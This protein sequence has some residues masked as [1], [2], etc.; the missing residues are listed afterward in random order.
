MKFW[1]KIVDIIM[2]SL[3][4]LTLALW[5]LALVKP[6]L[7]KDFIAWIEKIVY[8]LWN[9]NYLIVF[10]SW[11][12][13]WFPVLWVVVPWQ[14][15]LLIVW[16]F[17]AK[18]NKTNLIYVMILASLWAII[19]NYIWYLLWRYYWDSF[20]RKYWTWFWIWTT[21]L[22]YLKKW[23]EK[24]W[25]IGIILWK[26]H[27]LA[28]AFVP[29]IAWSMWMKNKVFFVY[30]II[31]SILRAIILIV[32]WVLFATYYQLII[33]YMMY[34]MIAV[35][36]IVWIYIYK[37]KKWEFLKYM[38]EKNKELDEQIEEKRKLKEERKKAKN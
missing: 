18:I 29:F 15:I 24:W 5:I 6:W 38:Q 19:S 11:L 33:D 21:E 23:I 20:F 28:R 35:T 16:G 13:E 25:P 8:T 14:N 26:F 32:L 9:L 27:N 31:W 2:K 37:F 34:I 10:L 36:V 30:N 4:F 3:I 7:V 17:F 1:A 12:V 22:K